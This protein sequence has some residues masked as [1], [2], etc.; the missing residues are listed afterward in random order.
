MESGATR[1]IDERR[2]VH[3]SPDTINNVSEGLGINNLSSAVAKELAEDVTYR[4]REIADVCSQFLR[5][6]RYTNVYF[7]FLTHI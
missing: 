6:S 5:H 1:N 4:L 3:L 2:Y 7:I